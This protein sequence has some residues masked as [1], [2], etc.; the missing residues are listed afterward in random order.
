MT[1]KQSRGI[2]VIILIII[3]WL[4]IVICGYFFYTKNVL[5]VYPATGQ[6]ANEILGQMGDYF[7]GMLN[8]IVGIIS[9]ILLWLAYSAQ[10]SELEKT[11]AALTEQIALSRDENSRVQIVEIIE[12][13]YLKHEAI[14]NSEFKIEM[15]PTS[16]SDHLIFIFDQGK[17]YTLAQLVEIFEKMNERGDFTDQTTYSDV[18]NSTYANYDPT[19]NE[20]YFSPVW[21]KIL[22]AKKNIEFIHNLAL[23]LIKVIHL[24]NIEKIWFHRYYDTLLKCKNAGVVSED[25]YQKFHF[26]MQAIRNKKFNVSTH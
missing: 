1:Q 23:D 20:T 16:S 10:K 11:S 25:E 19:Q 22:E 17:T 6:T 26:K 5:Y 12:K 7:G 14:F 18:V 24:K 15:E 4:I 8:P 3:P 9:V 13:Q 21:L 2:W